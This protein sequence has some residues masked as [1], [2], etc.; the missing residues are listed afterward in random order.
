VAFS[1]LCS[2]VIFAEVRRALAR[3][4]VQRK[5]RIHP[6]EVDELRHF[7]QSESVAVAIS[8]EVCGVATHPEDDLILATAVSADADYL[9]TGDRPLQALGSFRG[10]AIVS[11]RQFLAVLDGAEPD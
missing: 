7:L 2:V 4:R 9:V 5:Y 6:A 10:V 11:P 1:C 8:A 3:P